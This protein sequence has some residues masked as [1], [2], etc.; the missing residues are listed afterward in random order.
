MRVAS[1]TFS[2]AGLCPWQHGGRVLHGT[3]GATWPTW[4]RRGPR[5]RGI[6]KARL[7]NGKARPARQ[8]PPGGTARRQGDARRTTKPKLWKPHGGSLAVEALAVESGVEEASLWKP[9]C[10]SLQSDDTRDARPKPRSEAT[11]RGRSAG[12]EPFRGRGRGHEAKGCECGGEGEQERSDGGRE[13]SRRRGGRRSGERRG[14]GRRAVG[15]GRWTGGRRR[16]HWTT[17]S[18]TTTAPAAPSAL[19]LRPPPPAEE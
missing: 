3:G 14:S 11:A 17:Q 5:P 15:G 2:D 16:T 1:A 18:A 12:Q 7:T 9:R 13:R 8:R 6:C 19:P 10:E 4:Q